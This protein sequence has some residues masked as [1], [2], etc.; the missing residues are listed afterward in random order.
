MNENQK[1]PDY[2]IDNSV[3]EQ[4]GDSI[5]SVFYDGAN[6]RIEVGVTRLDQLGG[7]SSTMHPITRLV[8]PMPAANDLH[9]KLTGLFGQL[10]EQGVLKRAAQGPGGG[11]PDRTN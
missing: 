8:L 1:K 3:P 4:F 2:I 10:E 5:V 11:A 9:R 6:F 7:G